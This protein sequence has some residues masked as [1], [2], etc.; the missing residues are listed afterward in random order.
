MYNKSKQ[1]S[2]HLV[3]Y[4]FLFSTALLSLPLMAGQQQSIHS[5]LF[6]STMAENI[7]SSDNLEAK[8]LYQHAQSLYMQGKHAKAVQDKSKL[9]QAAIGNMLA[10]NSLLANSSAKNTK[11]QLANVS[12]VKAEVDE[13]RF[14]QQEKTVV[15]LLSAYNEIAKEKGV[16]EQTAKTSANVNALV[17]YAQE[18]WQQGH[19]SEAKTVLEQGY[20][21]VSKS[22]SALREGETL[23]ITLNFH[24]HQDEYDYYLSKV[25]SMLAAVNL[26]DL[27]KVT[28]RERDFLVK[29]QNNIRQL[30]VEADTMASKGDYQSA[31]KVMESAYNKMN[32]GLMLAMN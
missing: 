12:A 21:L 27:G 26:P 31:N 7:R 16:S 11:A 1:A 32:M 25:S 3:K 13:Q 4:L 29:V 2:S 30:L 18:Y 20:R 23:N 9:F 10:A 24:T 8:N 6:Q 14:K 22:L 28:A 17:D 5:M 19:Y 15:S